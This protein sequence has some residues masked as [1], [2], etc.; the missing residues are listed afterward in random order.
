MFHG[1]YYNKYH[2]RKNVDEYGRNIMTAHAHTEQTYLAM[3]YDERR[4]GISIPCLCDRNPNWLRGK[5][6][7][8]VHGFATVDVLSNGHYFDDIITI[9]NG[10][11]SR[12]G[13][14]YGG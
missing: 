12:N 2:A 5:P 4:K 3:Y 7:S 13:K 10:N 14:I 11:F 9:I 8:W 6:N 1:V